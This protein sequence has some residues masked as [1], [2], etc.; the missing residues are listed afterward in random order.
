[1]KHITRFLTIKLFYPP[2]DKPLN[3]NPFTLQ[4]AVQGSPL[5]HFA[6]SRGP[7]NSAECGTVNNIVFHS[8]YLKNG[9]KN[10]SLLLRPY[11]SFLITYTLIPTRLVV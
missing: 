10:M 2:S 11:V 5:I 7:N 9:L 3:S 4:K 1:M 6:I 8:P